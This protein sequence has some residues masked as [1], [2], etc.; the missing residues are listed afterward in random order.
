MVRWGRISKLYGYEPFLSELSVGMLVK[1]LEVYENGICSCTA[2]GLNY[3][4]IGFN[5]NYFLESGSYDTVLHIE[6]LEILCELDTDG[7]SGIVF[8]NGDWI[9]CFAT[10]HKYLIPWLESQ[11]HFYS[12]NIAH[13]SSGCGELLAVYDSPTESMLCTLN[14]LKELLSKE[15]EQQFKSLFY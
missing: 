12:D 6:Q 8:E 3:S 13:L 7:V 9:E 1:V 2:V 10:G 15:Q 5:D 4:N 14:L 11:G